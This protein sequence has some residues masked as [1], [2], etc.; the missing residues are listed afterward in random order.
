MRRKSRLLCDWRGLSFSDHFSKEGEFA[1]EAVFL[2]PIIFRRL[3]LVS[4][5]LKEEDFNATTFFR[6]LAFGLRQ[7]GLEGADGGRFRGQVLRFP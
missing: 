3:N 4:A 6:V 2:V 7:K 1:K 5:A